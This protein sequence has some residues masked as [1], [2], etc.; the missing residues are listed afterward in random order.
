VSTL[1]ENT[2]PKFCTVCG[3]PLIETHTPTREGFD[4]LTGIERPP[5]DHMVKACPQPI[6]DRWVPLSNGLWERM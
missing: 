4:P 5:R 6:H 2:P 3:R 1:P